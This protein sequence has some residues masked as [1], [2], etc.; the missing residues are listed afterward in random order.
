MAL[1][2]IYL[3]PFTHDIDL[4]NFRITNSEGEAI[5][6]KVKIRLLTFFAEWKLD[7]QAGT[8]WF[9]RILRKGVTEYNADQEIRKRV[10]ETEG[11]RA[12]RTF[13][14]TFDEK[15]RT[16]TCNFSIITDYDE[17]IRMGVPV[18]I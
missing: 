1:H 15:N 14:S 5:A 10:L 8:Y 4:D 7:R 17:E 12:L 18:E 16:Y 6:Q 2:D 13:K 3:D 9:E 11:V